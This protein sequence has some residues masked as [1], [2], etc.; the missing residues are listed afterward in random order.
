MKLL[1]LFILGILL[2]SCA[3][4]TQYTK[5]T[6]LASNEEVAQIYIIRK[7][8]MATAIPF[9]IYQDHRRVG[10]LGPKSY[11][12]LEIDEPGLVEIASFSPENQDIF[13]IDVQMGKTY[14]LRQRVRPGVY[15]PRTRLELMDPYEAEE[16]LAKLKGPKRVNYTR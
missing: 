12:A 16:A 13:N 14:F 2:S 8:F 6:D 9:I 7:S 10:K 15:A 1:H 5:F 3:T 4:T 11:L